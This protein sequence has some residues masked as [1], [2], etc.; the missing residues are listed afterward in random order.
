MHRVW[1]TASGQKYD[2]KAF[3]F[4]RDSNGKFTKSKNY[5][6][7]DPDKKYV[8]VF[9]DKTRNDEDK[10]Q[11]LYEVNFRYNRWRELG[12]CSIQNE[13]KQLR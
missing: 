10:Q 4:M 2:C 8:V 3:E 7:L 5:F 1:Q 9:L 6:N 13:H 12:Y 11:V